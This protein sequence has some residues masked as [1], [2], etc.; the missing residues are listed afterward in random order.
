[1]KKLVLIFSIASALASCTSEKEDLVNVVPRIGSIESS[2][3]VEHLNDSFDVLVTKHLVNKN[4]TTSQ[5]IM[6]RDT[7]PALGRT[8]ITDE[9]DMPRMV[10]KDY[11]IFITIK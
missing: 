2:V 5:S 8:A 10:Q 11:D 3:T 7:I 9:N 1:M 6:H 4:V